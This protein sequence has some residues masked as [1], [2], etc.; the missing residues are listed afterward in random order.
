MKAILIDDEQLALNYLEFQLNQIAD[1]N[2]IGKYKDPTV[3][4][5]K[6]EKNEVDIVFLDI[7]IPDM[8]GIK[9][10][11]QLLETK[12]NIQIVF[13]TAYD[14]Y[15]IKAFEL[16]ALDYVIK[17]VSKE[18]L[19]NTLHRFKLE[20]SDA[21]PVMNKLKINMFQQVTFLNEDQKIA[22]LKWRTT[23]VQQLF[24]FL[25]QRRGQIV[26]KS[27]LIELLWQDF[28]L[29]KAFSQ[30]YTAIYHIRKT[31]APFEKHFQITS[32]AEGYMLNVEN[33]SVDVDE[34]E[35]LIHTN[36]SLSLH[37]I[38]DYEKAITLYKG[39]YLQ[40]FDYTW[41][42]IERQRLQILFIHH[43]LK[44]LNWYYSN[45]YLDKAIELGVEICHRFPLEEE[46]YL[47]LMKSFAKKGNNISV[48]H[49]YLRLVEVLKEELEVNPTHSTREWYGNWRENTG[50]VLN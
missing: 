32:I 14:D 1:F 41:A 15:A 27:E 23:K 50:K 48:Y 38:A 49:T 44:V 5:T 6:I 28:E 24:L 31:L 35:K 16:N 22:P 11:E 25:L 3:A 29:P 10:A 9:L 8:N 13:V 46:V 4:K 7:H 37:T 39:E 47:I 18:R 43:S 21:I 36:Q 17:P 34:F 40:G 26:E 33:V 42:E 12:P 30:L 45:D 20:A 19:L 2:I